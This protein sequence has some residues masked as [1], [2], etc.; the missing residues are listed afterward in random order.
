MLT[1]IV[2]SSF[3][4]IIVIPMDAPLSELQ[5]QKLAIC[6]IDAAAVVV[7]LIYIYTHAHNTIGCDDLGVKI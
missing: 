1:T 7:V 3:I 4:F 5:S 6:S 2:S